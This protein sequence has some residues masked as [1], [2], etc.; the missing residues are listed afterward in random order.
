MGR[1]TCAELFDFIQRFETFRSIAH[2]YN[3]ANYGQ[4]GL[5]WWMNRHSRSRCAFTDNN[6]FTDAK[7]MSPKQN[8]IKFHVVEDENCFIKYQN[9]HCKSFIFISVF[10]SKYTLDQ[11]LIKYAYAYLYIIRCLRINEYELFLVTEVFDMRIFSRQYP[12]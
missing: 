12:F 10:W 4:K 5:L 9:A 3:L 6:L 8:E 2:L 1:Y 7:L 11:R